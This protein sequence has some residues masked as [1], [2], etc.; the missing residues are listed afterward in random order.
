[1]ASLG[2][3]ALVPLTGFIISVYLIRVL[4]PQQYGLYALLSVIIIWTDTVIMALATPV[5]IKLIAD[6][7]LFKQAGALAFQIHFFLGLC[8]SLFL[9]FVAPLIATFLRVEAI[10]PLLRLF[11]IEVFLFCLSHVHYASLTGLELYHRRAMVRA[12]RWITRMVLIIL[13]VEAGWAIWGAIVGNIGAV[14]LELISGRLSIRIPLQLKSTRISLKPFL[15]WSLPTILF[16]ISHEIAYKIDLLII[17]SAGASLQETSLYAAA[18]NL[19]YFPNFIIGATWFFIFSTLFRLIREKKQ[20]EIETLLRTIYKFWLMLLPLCA[21]ISV[22]AEEIS[23]LLYG[24]TF[25]KSGDFI[26]ILIFCSLLIIFLKCS[27]AILMAYHRQRW[28]ALIL[29]PFLP[30]LVLLIYLL[31]PVWG[32]RAAAWITL[33]VFSIA[34]LTGLLGLRKVLSIQNMV[35]PVVINLLLALLAYAIMTWIEGTGWMLVLQL[36]FILILIVSVYI[37]SGFFDNNMTAFLRQQ[38]RHLRISR[39]KS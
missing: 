21:V 27:A 9:V 18:Q 25:A 13:L 39:R 37:K 3:N 38:L 34:T 24:K 11:S 14:L 5:T 17:K 7:K 8:L 1:M 22:K 32:V 16:D 15:V 4:G 6:I 19:A 28:V 29:P 20:K 33:F 10:T 26:S 23:V 2:V 30:V 35:R 31:V 12:V 36:L